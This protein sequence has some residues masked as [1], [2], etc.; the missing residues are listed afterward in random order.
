MG[1]ATSLQCQKC[2]GS[3]STYPTLTTATT[4]T[5]ATQQHTRSEIRIASDRIGSHSFSTDELLTPRA[6]QHQYSTHRRY[7]EGITY[8]KST[9]DEIT[10]AAAGYH[11]PFILFMHKLPHD[12]HSLTPHQ[13]IE[14]YLLHYHH[15]LSLESSSAVVTTLSLLLYLVLTS[16]SSH[17]FLLRGRAGVCFAGLRVCCARSLQVVWCVH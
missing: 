9:H 11:I 17:A 10:A 12:T 6:Y 14:P 3:S 5:T 16:S 8:I 1:I 2:D 4:A 13:H 7:T 15:L